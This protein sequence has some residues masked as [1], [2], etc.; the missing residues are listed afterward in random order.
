[1]ECH[2]KRMHISLVGKIC[3]DQ[4]FFSGGPLKSQNEKIFVHVFF[5]KFS[6]FPVF[7]NQDFIF[8]RIVLSG[9]FSAVFI[10]FAIASSN[11]CLFGASARRSIISRASPLN[12]SS[13]SN[14]FL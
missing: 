7:S 5:P 2:N 12:S 1:M 14:I 8:E 6:C 4:N 11:S 13:A 3:G 10:N 9:H